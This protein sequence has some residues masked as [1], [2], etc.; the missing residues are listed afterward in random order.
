MILLVK[1]S[2]SQK[3]SGKVY[4]EITVESKNQKDNQKFSIKENDNVRE[5][6]KLEATLCVMLEKSGKS[7]LV[8]DKLCWELFQSQLPWAQ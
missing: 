1:N 8:R 7:A 4:E 5:Q 6:E 2:F 3:I